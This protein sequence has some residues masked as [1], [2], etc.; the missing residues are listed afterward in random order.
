MRG[1]ALI[2][3]QKELDL[4]D[5]DESRLPVRRL[6]ALVIDANSRVG[7][8]Q[9]LEDEYLPSKPSKHRFGG[10]SGRDRHSM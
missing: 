3:S 1:L 4:S 2:D 10:D 7:S 9:V 8:A 6:F 5:Q